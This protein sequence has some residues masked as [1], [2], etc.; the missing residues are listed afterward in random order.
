MD[1]KGIFKA[2]RLQIV[3]ALV[4]A[5]SGFLYWRLVGCNSGTCLIK[6]VWYWSTLWGTVMG[7]LVGDM[8]NDFIIK[9]KK[10]RSIE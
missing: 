5:I 8:I 2:K 7:Y 4:G 10:R 9:R 6:S 1:I 3:F